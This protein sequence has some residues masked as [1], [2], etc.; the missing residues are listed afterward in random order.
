MTK[1]LQSNI[2]KFLW[3][4]VETTGLNP[5]KNFVHQVA[6]QLIIDGVIVDTFDYKFRPFETPLMEDIPGKMA[7]E[8][9][10]ALA[11]S[12]LTINDVMSRKKTSKDCY[13]E[14][15]RMLRKH[16]DKFDKN[17]KAVIGAYNAG[18]DAQFL[19]SWYNNHGNKY[20]FGLCHGGAYFDPLQMALML[21]IK[22]GKRLFFPNRKLPTM[23]EHFGIELSKAHDAAHDIAA[24]RRLAGVLWHELFG[25]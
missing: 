13:L 16:I 8:M 20:F 19:S 4:D 12:G 3:A 25:D 7:E 21:E 6:G 18:F 17:D 11:V 15:D 5:E 24:T 1:Y 22:K 2:S 23:C 14:F 10:E 9:T